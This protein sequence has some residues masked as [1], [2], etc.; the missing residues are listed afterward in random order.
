MKIPGLRASGALCRR[1]ELHAD[2]EKS[3]SELRVRKVCFPGSRGNSAMIKLF[4]S[5][6]FRRFQKLP[7]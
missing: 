4:D 3:L 1:A 5:A 2:K 6:C 7:I